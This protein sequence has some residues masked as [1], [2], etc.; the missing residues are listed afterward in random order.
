MQ[1]RDRLIIAAVAAVV[2]IGA[3]WLLLVSPERHEASSL[4]AQIATEQA[5]L[6]TAQAS[7]ASARSA[8]AG[9][10]GNVH[11]LAQV[12][13]AI[14]ASVDEPS[15]LRTITRLAGTT[16]DVHS[17]SVGG[18]AT[19]AQGTNALALTFQFNTTYGSLQ[20]FLVKLDRLIR[21]DG[22]NLVASGR[23]FTVSS[24]SFVP[25]PSNKISATVTA[26]AFS[27]GGTGAT[28]ATGATGVAATAAVTP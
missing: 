7:L 27:Q 21:T 8:A 12:T 2:A 1:V 17:V 23:L 14:P 11:A 19:T 28:G 5:S 16:V 22:T 9:Y 20:N 10:R 13:T 24:I 26:N 3:V 15:V 4:S 25:Q 6:A 18:S